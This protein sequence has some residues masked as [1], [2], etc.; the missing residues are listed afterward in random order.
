MSFLFA[1][2]GGAAIFGIIT[3]FAKVP[4]ARRFLPFLNWFVDSIVDYLNYR[5]NQGKYS[6]ITLFSS[7]SFILARAVVLEGADLRAQRKHIAE[8]VSS[9]YTTLLPEEEWGEEQERIATAAYVALINNQEIKDLVVS[10][11]IN[12][13]YKNLEVRKATYLAIDIL[14]EIVDLS[15]D[16]GQEYFQHLIYGINK[17]LVRIREHGLNR[18][19]LKKIVSI[20]YRVYKLSRAYRHLRTIDK[21]T[22]EEFYEK[23]SSG[24]SLI[25][26]L[27]LS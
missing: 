4:A 25:R 21:M 24:L 20:L 17:S 22:K 1:I 15:D 18:D 23:V 3:L 27:V 9:A 10:L 19:N 26:N 6:A 2:L 13:D 16:L 7:R 11:L 5:N 8:I 12:K 14:G